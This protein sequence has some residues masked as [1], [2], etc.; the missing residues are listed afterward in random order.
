MVIKK[1]YL[2]KVFNIDTNETSYLS[3][4]LYSF[5]VAWKLNSFRWNY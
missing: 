1:N 5:Y 2:K 3:L 4:F